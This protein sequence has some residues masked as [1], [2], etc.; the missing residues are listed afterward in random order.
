MRDKTCC[1]AGHREIPS[2]EYESISE[3]LKNEIV[4]LIEEGYL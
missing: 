2:R 1:F 4:K 3:R